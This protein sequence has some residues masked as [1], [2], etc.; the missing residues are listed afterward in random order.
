VG[1]AKR[2]VRHALRPARVQY[3]TWRRAGAAGIRR[4]TG[5][6]R[7]AAR[8]DAV[9]ACIGRRATFFRCRITGGLRWHGD[10]SIA[11]MRPAFQAIRTTP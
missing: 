11:G 5:K 9:V 1:T 10:C 3:G 2:D 6:R 7:P 8:R 4:A